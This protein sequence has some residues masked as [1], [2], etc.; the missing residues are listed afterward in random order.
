MHKNRDTTVH[1]RIEGKEISA[2]EDRQS[3]NE[4]PAPIGLALRG[5]G[6]N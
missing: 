5:N 2:E 6:F 4:Y 3:I 1:V